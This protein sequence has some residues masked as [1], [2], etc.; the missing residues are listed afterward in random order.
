LGFPSELSTQQKFKYQ[1]LFA[2]VSFMDLYGGA[3]AV[4]KTMALIL[5]EEL[6]ALENDI[7]MFAPQAD[8]CEPRRLFRECAMRHANLWA[9][10]SQL[11]VTS[12]GWARDRYSPFLARPLKFSSLGQV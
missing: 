4:T 3:D 2:L 5:Y 9:E 12:E 10:E 8:A 7:G 1:A 6:L 11:V